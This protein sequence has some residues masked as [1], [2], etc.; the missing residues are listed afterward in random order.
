VAQNAPSV[1]IGWGVSI[2]PQGQPPLTVL[3]LQAAVC[4]SIQSPRL[5][6][7]A[8][9]VTT[10]SGGTGRFSDAIGTLTSVT[11][12]SPISFSGGVLVNSVEGTITT[13]QIS[14]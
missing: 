11:E 9:I 4:G 13:G 8:P 14:Y 3:L 1:A 2:R 10:V 12:V 6:A 7:R 5:C